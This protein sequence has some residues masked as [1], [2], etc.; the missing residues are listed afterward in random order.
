MPTPVVTLPKVA[1][2]I[3]NVGKSVKLA[4]IDYLKDTAPNTADFLETNNDLF[5]EIYSS[6]VNYKQTIQAAKTKVTKSKI[7]DTG[8]K[9]KNA[10]I[11]D[12]KTGNFYNKERQ[13]AYEMAGI[14]ID[15]GDFDDFDFDTSVFD[16]TDTSDAAK[17]SK[18]FDLAMEA[19]TKAQASITFKSADYIAETVKGSTSA[20]FAQNE[21]MI[22]QM[23]AGMGSVHAAVGNVFNFM[24]GPM[25][26]HFQNTLQYQQKS[27]EHFNKMESM[28]DELLQM[29]RNLY[30][31]E[32]EERK[33]TDFENVVGASGMPD[34]REYAKAIMKN[35]KSELGP[36]FDMLFGDSFGKDANPLLLLIGAPLKVIPE[37]VVK[38]VIPATVKKA[39]ETFDNSISGLFST[40]I[41]KLN[42]MSGSDNELLSR[43]GRIFGL[44]ID[45]KTTVSTDKI[46]KGAI[47]FDGVTKQAIVEV[48]PGHL[49]RIEAALTGQPER[50]Y[51]V[52]SGRW[53]TV[54]QI[55]K[56]YRDRRQ[57][58]VNMGFYEVKK[59]M[60]TYLYELRKTN[61]VRADEL[62]KSVQKVM[63][64]IFSDN[65]YFSPYRSV[66]DSNKGYKVSPDKYYGVSP[67]DF[68]IIV[69]QFTKDRGAL[70]HLAQ[71]VMDQRESWSRF[72]R[73]IENDGSNVY[74]NLFSGAYG[75]NVYQD[76]RDLSI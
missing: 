15:M 18:A 24:Q 37:M 27:L 1:N 28:M 63:E 22:A 31:A 25:M 40:L 10:L 71:E 3:K 17:Q 34:L 21:R 23:T 65:G 42:K 13:E 56:E 36:E 57:A 9:L 6:T 66:Y 45:K 67:E 11:E 60:D 38:A 35:T 8:G 54:K 69:E 33:Y 4:S 16:K 30:N 5:K 73:D 26:T 2:Y 39:A 20:L 29:Q 75:K 72:L 19:S 32:R 58:N 49:R 68:K 7:W 50:L 48:I 52:N 47:P 53:K 46:N 41:S 74:R 51:D 70:M 12:L 61:Q 55:E 62:E 64:K 76:L 43:I 14:G 59:E 44:R